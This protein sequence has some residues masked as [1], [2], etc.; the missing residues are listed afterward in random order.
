[1]WRSPLCAN[2]RHSDSAAPKQTGERDVSETQ[3][4]EER[5]IPGDL[6]LV[7]AYA[8]MRTE[9]KSRK[10]LGPCGS[11]KSCSGAAWAVE[12]GTGPASNTVNTEV[13]SVPAK[14]CALAI[15][16]LADH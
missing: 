10:T 13:G 9:F 6:R 1:M 4:V 11:Y 15:Y 12:E 3:Q 14:L 7:R 2:D 8:Q 16:E 5:G